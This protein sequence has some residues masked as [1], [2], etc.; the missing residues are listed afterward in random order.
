MKLKTVALSFLLLSSLLNANTI[1]NID[2]FNR[3]KK[4]TLDFDEE[5]YFQLGVA[6]YEGLVVKKDYKK[7]YTNFKKASKLYHEKA[8]YNLAIMYSNKKTPYYNLKKSYSL[9]LALAKE[10]NAGAQNRIGM[11]LTFGLVV[12][13]DYKE[14]VKWFE[15]SSKQNYLT[16]HCNLAYMYASGSGVFVN[17]GRAN[18]FAK[19][20]LKSK[21]PICTKVYKEYNL[22]KYKED[23]GW[24][25][26]FY[27][28]PE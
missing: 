9:F 16:A 12:D 23:K 26:K 6:Y 7:A 5:A 19:E 4:L 3:Y 11:F 14:A 25:F 1:E 15:K 20:G 24:K 27:T 22:H 28:K 2:D 21:H 8:D 13:K 10:G 17:F 18:A